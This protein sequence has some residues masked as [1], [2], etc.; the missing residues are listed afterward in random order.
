MHVSRAGPTLPSLS[1]RMPTRAM[2][3]ATLPDVATRN[4]AIRAREVRNIMGNKMTN[5]SF[6]RCTGLTLGSPNEDVKL[7]EIMGDIYV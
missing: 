7:E 6:L 5:I 4:V 1:R 2:K 3:D